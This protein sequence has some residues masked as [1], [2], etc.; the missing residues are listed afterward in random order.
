MIAYYR[1]GLPTLT[2]SPSGSHSGTWAVLLR[3]NRKLKGALPRFI[4]ELAERDPQ[5]ARTLQQGVVPYDLI[6]HTQTDLQFQARVEQNGS[7]VGD[8]LTLQ[9][10]LS[11]YGVPVEHRASVWADIT[12]PDQS[13]RTIQMTE[14]RPGQFETS[15]PMTSA[16]LYALRV[17]AKGE[18]FRGSVFQ[19]EQSLNAV[20]FPVGYEPPKEPRGNSSDL[21][22]LFDCLLNQGA[23]NDRA[24]AK[25]KENG[26]DIDRLR[27]C[28]ETH[29]KTPLHNGLE[30]RLIGPTDDVEMVREI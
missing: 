22:H 23:L 27:K 19:R 15:Q 17:R 26:V 7:H 11:E 6:V 25:L 21:C 14:F 4:K 13:V 20:A 18:T 30:E 16:G 2:N 8:N 1:C 12:F 10:S 24:L 3:L 9:A 28:F 5:L 29:C